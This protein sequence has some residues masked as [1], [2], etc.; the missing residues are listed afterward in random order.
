MTSYAAAAPA[1]PVQAPRRPRPEVII[2]RSILTV[3]M[4]GIV[5]AFLSPLAYSALMS[6]K[7]EAQYSDPDSPILPSEARTFEYQGES[8]DV[9]YVPM[10]DGSTRELA[11]V[12]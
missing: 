12:R 4:S 9:Y 2:R 3:V 10:A 7:T 1:R 11:L 6:L 8:Y 5:I